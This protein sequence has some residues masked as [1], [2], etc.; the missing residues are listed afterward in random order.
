[1]LQVGSS[2]STNSVITLN[3]ADDSDIDDDFL[4]F[5]IDGFLDNEDTSAEVYFKVCAPDADAADSRA[6]WIAPTGRATMS[7]SDDDGVHDDVLG[8]DLVCP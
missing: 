8:A 7:V 1:M 2:L 5:T 3:N 6:I 4:R